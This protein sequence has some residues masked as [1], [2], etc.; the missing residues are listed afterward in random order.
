M[1]RDVP[2]RF[3]RLLAKQIDTVEKL[4]ILAA[5]DAAPE[6]TL[7]VDQLAT[8]LRVPRDVVRPA[9]VELRVIGLVDVTSRGAV[10]L[11]PLSDDDQ[12]AVDVLLAAYDRDPRS[13]VGL[14]GEIAMERIRNMVSR[15]VTDAP[16]L[17]K[18]GGED[19][20]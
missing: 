6:A 9:I 15:A 10:R 7:T 11:V 13:I 20:G 8:G 3:R 2:D 18:N 17:G 4:E 14:L 19:D 5:L 12:K 16:M 1:L